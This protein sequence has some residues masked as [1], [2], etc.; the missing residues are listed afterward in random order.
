MVDFL[1]FDLALTFKI[2]RT[3]IIVFIVYFG[4]NFLTRIIKKK[5]IEKAKTKRERTNIEV[6]SDIAH[7]VLILFLLIFAILSY[8]GSLTG[9]GVVAGLLSAA[10]GWAL[11]RPISGIAGWLMVIIKRPFE[12][13]DRIIIGDVK[14]DVVD[15]T[16]THIHIKEI[17]GTIASEETSGRLILIPNAKLFE[18]DIINYTKR[19]EFILDQVGF[20]ITFESDIEEAQKIAISSAKEVMRNYTKK[21]KGEIYTRTYFQSS[22]VDILIRYQSLTSKRNQISSEITQKIFKKV[23]ISK[24][25]KF[26]YQHTEI[27]ISREQKK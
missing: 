14:G 10:L 12:M 7:Y 13:G 17:G 9:I 5:L 24:N 11:Q 1:N 19:D 3:I 22:G 15:I 18:Q 23:R 2:L 20:A 16:L 4:F 21:I 26:A 27:S 25:V 8:A 6:F